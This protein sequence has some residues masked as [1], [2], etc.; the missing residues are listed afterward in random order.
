MHIEKIVTRIN[1]TGSCGYEV[2]RFSA[3]GCTHEHSTWQDAKACWDTWV[4]PEDKRKRIA[5]RE[6]ELYRRHKAAGLCSR[7]G[8]VPPVKE[9]T[10]CRCCLADCAAANQR[11]AAKRGKR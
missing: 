4:T 2:E 6:R 1:L 11:Y 8:V 5:T 3:N 10:K 7:C 9:R